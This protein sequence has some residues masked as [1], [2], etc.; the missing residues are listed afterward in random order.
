MANLVV[1]LDLSRVVLVGG[2]A[3]VGEPLRAG[4]AAALVGLLPGAD[5]RPV[6]DVVLAQLG[7]DAGAL[8]AALLAVEPD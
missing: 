8:G 3:D 2:L 1:L 6:V 5:A 4:V 7:A